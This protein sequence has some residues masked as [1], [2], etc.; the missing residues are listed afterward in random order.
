ML[1]VNL[2]K[3][4][5]FFMHSQRKIT[6][7]RALWGQAPAPGCRLKLTRCVENHG[8]SG[9]SVA[10]TCLPPAPDWCEWRQF[11]PVQRCWSI[12]PRRW[13]PGRHRLPGQAGTGVLRPERPW[14]PGRSQTAR[15]LGR[16]QMVLLPGSCCLLETRPGRLGPCWRTGLPGSESQDASTQALALWVFVVR[17]RVADLAL[18]LPL[19]A[20][21]L[22]LR[23]SFST[24]SLR[25]SS[26]VAV[27]RPMALTT[28]STRSET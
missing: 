17:L 18:V 4:F 5:R 7:L 1:S 20:S 25:S 8:I 28:R 22:T 14:P 21:L 15:A 12:P 3:L 11:P 27:G 26:W 23:A 16:A 10:S 19:A 9:A 24:R 6:A 13:P 2:L